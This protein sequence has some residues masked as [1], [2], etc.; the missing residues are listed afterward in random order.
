[1]AIVTNVGTGCGGR[2]SVGR[3]MCSQGGSSVSGH[4]CADDR[5]LNASVETSSGSMRA[6]RGGWHEEAA[7]GKTAWSWHPLLVS[8]RWR[9]SGPTGSSIHRQSVGDG[10]QRN[11]APGRSRHKPINH[12]A[13]KA[14]CSGAPAVHRVH[15]CARLRVSWAPGFPCALYFRRASFQEGF[16][17][18]ITSGATAPRDRNVVSSAGRIYRAHRLPVHSRDWTAARNARMLPNSRKKPIQTGEKRAV[19]WE[20]AGLN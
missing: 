10:G 2:G 9:W 5:R 8:S 4:A 20:S 13:G 12:C 6:G 18:R 3:G 7:D 11:S 15:S 16:A 17:D 14:G 19:L 1:L